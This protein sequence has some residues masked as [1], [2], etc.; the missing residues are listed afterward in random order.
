M[1]HEFYYIGHDLWGYRYNT[2]FPPTPTLYGNNYYGYKNAASQVLFYDFAVQMYDVKFMYKG[3]MYYLLYTP[4]YAALSDEKFTDEIEIF[5]TP[6][7]LI[8]NLV[9]NGEKLLDIIDEIEEIEP[10]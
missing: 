9:I 1:R 5:E 7:D 10:V 6:N 3:K 8:K 2:E 4:E